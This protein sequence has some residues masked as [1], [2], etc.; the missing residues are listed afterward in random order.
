MF[1][2]FCGLF[3]M[4]T[5]EHLFRFP[6]L[7]YLQMQ[8]K[9]AKQRKVALKTNVTTALTSKYWFM[10][11]FELQELTNSKPFGFPTKLSNLVPTP[12]TII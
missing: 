5:H 4:K 3:Y 10:D 2:T 6:Q 12:N 11:L 1:D 7:A 8:R 9:I